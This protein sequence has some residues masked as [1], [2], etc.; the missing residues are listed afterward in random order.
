MRSSA[1]ARIPAERTER[2]RLVT[3]GDLSRVAAIDQWR[4]AGIEKWYVAVNSRVWEFYDEVDVASAQFSADQLLLLARRGEQWVLVRDNETIRVLGKGA[5]AWLQVSADG[6]HDACVQQVSP[7]E[8]RV[9]V[10]GQP[11][12]E[13]YQQVVVGAFSGDSRHYAYVGR[14]GGA[15]SYVR[16]GQVLGTV[17]GEISAGLAWSGE[18]VIGAVSTGKEILH[19]V[20]GRVVVRHAV[21]AGARV[22][23]LHMDAGGKQVYWAE[24]D[25]EGVYVRPSEAGRVLPYEEITAIATSPGGR[26]LALV[27]RQ[28]KQHVLL[29]DFREVERFPDRAAPVFVQEDHLRY[30]MYRETVDVLR[31]GNEWNRRRDM[32][33]EDGR[34]EISSS[35]GGVSVNGGHVGMGRLLKAASPETGRGYVLVEQP[36]EL[37]INDKPLYEVTRVELRR[38]T[39]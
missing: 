19:V 18:Q 37:V 11:A 14:R 10:D 34:M 17:S 13:V 1:V 23:A 7:D 22:T 29:V 12:G 25:R 5:C 2:F 32:V 15:F 26:H 24:K 36:R 33:T 27:G 4:E 20:N 8:Q 6:L 30:I 21:T 16:D 38:K 31:W 39:K 28:E 9:L 3:N 35:G